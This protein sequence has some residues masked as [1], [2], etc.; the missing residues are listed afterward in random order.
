[1]QLGGLNY[2]FG[3]PVQK[4]LLGDPLDG[5]EWNRFPR[6]RWLLYSVTLFSYFMVGVWLY[7]R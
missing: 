5:L 2:Y 6:V 1:M 4:P 3:R 7:Y